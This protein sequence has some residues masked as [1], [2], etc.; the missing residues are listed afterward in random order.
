MGIFTRKADQSVLNI[1]FLL[2]A[3]WNK[4]VYFKITFKNSDYFT[5]NIMEYFRKVGWSRLKLNTSSYPN[6]S[7][8]IIM[9]HFVHG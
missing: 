6:K 3:Y 8:S 2:P 4:Q 9:Q 1:Q 7:E 5:F